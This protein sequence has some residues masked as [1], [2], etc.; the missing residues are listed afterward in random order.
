MRFIIFFV[1]LSTVPHRIYAKDNLLLHCL[2]K[3][4]EKLHKEK[5][6]SVLY[7]LN[8]NFINELATSNDVAIKKNYVDEIC[9]PKAK[10]S[11]S[12][13][14]LRLLLLNESDVF[15]LSLSGVDPSMRSYKMAYIREFQ[16]Q[17]PHIFISY[18]AGLQT[19]MPDAHCLNNA[20]PEIAAFNQRLKYLE[21]E[22]TI[23]ELLSQKKKIDK[24]FNRLKN[25]KAI[26]AD[27]VKKNQKK[28][29]SGPKKKSDT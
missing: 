18:L 21:E 24:I 16:K 22:I 1:L 29:K 19:E 10:L 28:L 20:I 13:G 7:R 5:N 9:S 23:H 2:G 6:Q 3:E 11:P 17:V 27:C 14:L 25:L 15:D 8:Q 4:E 12:V 26:A